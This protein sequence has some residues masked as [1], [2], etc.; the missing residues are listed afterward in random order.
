MSVLLTA[1]ELEAIQEHARADYPAECCGVLLVR[2]EPAGE[3][4]LIACRN[5]QDERHAED[6]D[7][8]PRTSRA[9][10]YMHP[11]DAL[12]AQQ[13]ETNGYLLHVIYHSHID[14]GAYFSATD[15]RNATW[16]GGPW[17]GEP[18]YPGCTY[19]VVSIE[20]RQI[21]ETRAHRWSPTERKFVE[22]PLVV[23]ERAVRAENR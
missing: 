4:R 3:R 13:A 23:G 7:R 19:V 8:Y 16:E 12:H 6:P 2:P 11:K 10:Y 1:A 22:V 17:D 14:V 15:V 20:G 9:A 18:S 5:I 21:R